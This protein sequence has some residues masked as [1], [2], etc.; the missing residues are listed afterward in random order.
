MLFA[1]EV[2]A[3]ATRK[4]CRLIRVGGMDNEKLGSLVRDSSS[5]AGAAAVTHKGGG[6]KGRNRG[7]ASCLAP[8]HWLPRYDVWSY[9]DWG[10][11]L[12]VTHSAE[13]KELL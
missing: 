11:L 6:E 2:I 1:S 9:A 3:A 13:C 10:T 5:I 8:S 7:A 12:T 4:G